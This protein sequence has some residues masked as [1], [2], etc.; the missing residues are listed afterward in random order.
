V[1][2]VSKPT[3]WALEVQYKKYNMNRQGY[4]TKGLK[5]KKDKKSFRYKNE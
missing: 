5:K 2:Y 4:R 3:L 1:K